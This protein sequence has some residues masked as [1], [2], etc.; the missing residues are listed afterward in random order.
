MKRAPNV[1]PDGLYEVV[2]SFAVGETTYQRG[3]KVRGDTRS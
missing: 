1:D 3:T 2:E